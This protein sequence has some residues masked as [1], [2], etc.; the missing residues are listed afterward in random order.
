MRLDLP[1]GQHAD[2]RDR[3][4]YGQGRAVRVALLALEAD[5]AA[6]ADLDLA[7]VEAFVADWHVLSIDGGAVPLADAASAPDDVIQAIALAAMDLWKGKPDPKGTT[8]PSRTTSRARRSGSMTR[9]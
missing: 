8:A 6:L 9:P 1:G 4:T 5:R 7:L 2:L 3:L